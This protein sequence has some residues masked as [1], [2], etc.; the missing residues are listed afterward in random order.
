MRQKIACSDTLA[1]FNIPTQGVG[2][3]LEFLDKTYLAKL[4]GWGYCMVKIAC[5]DFDR[6]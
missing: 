1:L 6:F 4:Q 3:P 5:A 2:D